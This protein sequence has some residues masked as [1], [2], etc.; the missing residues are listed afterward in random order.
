MYEKGN[1]F[2]QNIIKETLRLTKGSDLIDYE[3]PADIKEGIDY[4]LNQYGYPGEEEDVIVLR[5]QRELPYKEIAILTGISAASVGSILTTFRQVLNFSPYRVYLLRGL[6]E[7]KIH[8]AS[9]KE[10]IEKALDPSK[11]GYADY[12]VDLD[13]LDSVYLGYFGISLNAAKLLYHYRVWK[14]GVIRLFS[15]G[16]WNGI[17]PYFQ[18]K[19][20]ERMT[21]L[22]ADLGLFS[23]PSWNEKDQF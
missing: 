18:K 17:M 13:R 20:S 9:V 8:E 10:L 14:L 6:S 15:K 5:F 3:V 21:K 19:D 4:V 22:F 23:H 2:Y 7:G 1:E 12:S 11:E 16:D